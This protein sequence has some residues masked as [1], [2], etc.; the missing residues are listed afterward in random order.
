M[1]HLSAVSKSYGGRVLFSNATLRVQEGNRIGLIGANGAGKSTLFSLI[2]GTTEADAGMVEVRKGVSFGFLP[3]ESAPVADE[4]VLEL[5]CSI[6]PRIAD[7]YRLLKQ[8]PNPEDS[9]NRTAQE[10]LAEEEVHLLEPRAKRILAGL[11][12]REGDIHRAARELSG[13]WI[14]RT[15]LARLLVQA[16]DLLMLD[17]PTNHLDLESLGW[18]QNHLR[19]YTGA[20][21]VISHDREFLNTICHSMVEIAYGK[22]HHYQGNYDAYLRQKQERYEQQKAAYENQQREIAHIQSFVDRFRYKASKAA[23]AQARIKQLEKMELIEAPE[24]AESKVRFRFPAVIRSGHKVIE[25]QQ[26]EQAY[27]THVIYRNLDLIV[28]RGD[29]IVLVGPNGAGKST[30][31]KILADVVPIQAGT[32]TVG[33]QVEIGYFS[34][35]RTEQLNLQ[36]TVLDEAMSAKGE[37]T[38]EQVRS[39]L[40]A[41]LFRGDDVDKRVSVLSGGEKSRLALLK[42]LLNPPNLLLLDEPTTHLDINSI[43]ALIAALQDF[44][45]TLVFVSH[46]VHFI[47]QLASRVWHIDRGVLTPYAGNYDYY[48]EKSQTASAREGLVQSLSDHRPD[49]KKNDTIAPAAGFQNAK[50]RRREA[51]MRQDQLAK[52]KRAI[53]QRIQ[54]SEEK[55]L[56]LETRQ[57]ELT[58]SMESPEAFANPEKS[59]SLHK[60]LAQVVEQLQQA[61]H[62]WEQSTEEWLSLAD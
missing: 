27:G 44:A 34:Q 38:Y 60:E 56:L 61:N 3:Q 15:H 50:D 54:A 30:L 55:I 32:R 42:L 8:Y 40:G 59:K 4:T 31:L 16:P 48:L 24:D 14:M 25:L 26:V 6:N 57:A 9:E 13:G 17:E 21:L 20:L 12:F 11:A 1:I 35:Q 62:E 43:D 37:H 51:A 5:A 10:I 39:L 7:A 58:Q 22:L 29:R 52:Q 36:H 45:G 2:L 28:E 49:A 18:F 19:Q 23:Q 41:F 47:R 53:Q 46:D 33:H